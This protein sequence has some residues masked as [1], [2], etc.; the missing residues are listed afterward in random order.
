MNNRH[1]KCLGRFV[2][3]NDAERELMERVFAKAYKVGGPAFGK[4]F[5]LFYG[6]SESAFKLNACGENPLAVPG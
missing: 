4:L 6:L 3:I 2:A 1:H 5:D